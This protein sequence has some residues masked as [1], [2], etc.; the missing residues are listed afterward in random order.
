MRIAFVPGFS[1]PAVAWDPTLAELPDALRVQAV[2]LDVPHG[3]DFVATAAALGDTAGPG[4]YVGYSMGG[5]LALRLALDRPEDVSALVLVST[6]PGLEATAAREERARIDR[7][8]AHDINARGV[9]AFLEDW[10]AQPL[11]ATLPRAAAM[12]DARAATMD[13]ARLAH[14]M[15][16]LGQGAMEPLWSRLGELA[17]PV[18]VVVGRAD[19]RYTE[20]GH[21]MVERTHDARLVEL[22]GGHALPLEQPHA[23]AVTVAEVHAAT[24]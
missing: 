23:L 15:T 2:A 5:R 13:P 16:A 6:S 21:A 1:Q 9:A 17:M 7:E 18:T 3:R 10:L 19:A 20:I 12:I 14:Q 8:R 22:D 4:I 11:F 24:A